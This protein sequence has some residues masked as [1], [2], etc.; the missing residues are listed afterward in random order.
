MPRHSTTLEFLATKLGE[1]SSMTN[2]ACQSLN[3]GISIQCF[4]Q[5]S[6]KWTRFLSRGPSSL[7]RFSEEGVD[8]LTLVFY[9]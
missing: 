1:S 6:Q 4:S 3:L 2:S 8:I 7:K 9:L 5:W